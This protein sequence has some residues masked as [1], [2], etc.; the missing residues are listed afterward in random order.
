MR[1]GQGDI[2]T[3]WK[4]KLQTMAASVTPAGILAEQHR[5]QA[6]PGSGREK[7]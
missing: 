2:V 4:N 1:K 7:S 5:R 3:G 6:E